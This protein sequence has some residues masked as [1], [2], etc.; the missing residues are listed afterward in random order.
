MA[1]SAKQLADAKARQAANYAKKNPA[2]VKAVAK[3]PVPAKYIPAKTTNT[4]AN[5]QV[6]IGNLFNNLRSVAPN[7]TL[8]QPST[9]SRLVAPSTVNQPATIAQSFD[10]TKTPTVSIKKNPSLDVSRP[11][12]KNPSFVKTITNSLSNIQKDIGYGVKNPKEV[13][14]QVPSAI[15]KVGNTVLD[16]TMRGISRIPAKA[17]SQ[18]TGQTLDPNRNTISKFVLGSDPVT[19]Y[20]EDMA[21]MQKWLQGKGLTKKQAIPAALVGS[22]GQIGLDYFGFGEGKVAEKAIVKATTEQAAKKALQKIGVESTPEMI[23][24]VI[25]IATPEEAKAF[26]SEAKNSSLYRAIAK[27]SSADFAKETLAGKIRPDI[28]DNVSTKLATTTDERMVKTIVD[29]AVEASKQ[30]PLTPAEI[31]S[32]GLYRMNKDKPI[33]QLEKEIAGSQATAKKHGL[34][35]DGVPEVNKYII[36]QKKAADPLLQGARKIN[37]SDDIVKALGQ[38]PYVSGIPPRWMYKENGVPKDVPFE[39]SK[40]LNKENFKFAP[41][42]RVAKTS[43]NLYHT[44]S[45]DNLES[46][47]KNGL[48]I[49]NKARFEG[50][51]SPNRLSFSAN[52]AGANYYGKQGDIMIRT[53]TSYKPTDLQHDLLAG[54]EGAYTT[55]KNIPP[56]ELEVKINGEWVSLDSINQSKGLPNH[57]LQEARR[58]KSA[59]ELNLFRDYEKSA[60]VEKGIDIT[61]KQFL[62]EKAKP[63]EILN[64]LSPESRKDVLSKVGRTTSITS[65]S[66]PIL[67]SSKNGYE[68]MD[69]GHA[70]AGKLKENKPIEYAKSQLTDIWKEAQGETPTSNPKVS[71]S[72]V[73]PKEKRPRIGNSEGSPSPKKRGFIET[74]T[75]SDQTSPALKSRLEQAPGYDPITNAET[76]A[77]AKNLVKT[78]P[79]AAEDFVM[80]AKVPSAGHTATGIELIKKLQSQGRYERAA[81]IA[82]SLAEKL[83]KAGQ[84]IQA[85]RL[86]ENLSPEGVLIRAQK[87]IKEA[88]AN[89]WRWQKD[90]VL[91]GATAK[92]LSELAKKMGEVGGELKTEFADE[93]GSILNNLKRVTIGKKIS[94]A[95]TIAQLLNP[96]TIITRNPLGNELFYRL[97]RVNKYL[98]TPIDWARSVLTGADRTVTFRSAK[99]GEFWKNFLSGAKAGWQGKELRVKTQFDLHGEVFKSKWNPLRYAE[100]ALGATL[101]GF[102]NAAFM[103]AKNET[104]GEMAYLKAYNE[105][106]RGGAVKEAAIKYAKQVDDNV[107]QIA[108]NYGKYVTFQDENILSKGFSAVKRGL[109]VGQDF[110]LGDLVLKY[111]KTPGAL[112]MRGIEYSPAGFLKSAYDIAMPILKG[113]PINSREVTLGLTRAIIGT[114]GLT[115]MGYY[116]A[117]KGIITGK[118]NKDKDV[119][120]FEKTTGTGQYKINLSAL[121]RFVMS[122]FDGSSTEKQDGDW[123]YSYDWA[124]PLAVAVSIGANINQE[125]GISGKGQAA[126]VAESIAGASSTIQEQPLVSGL[127]KMFGYGDIL[128]GLTET[129]KGLPSSFTP[130]LSNQFRQYIDNQQRSTYSPTF[131]GQAKNLVKNKIPGLEKY[132]PEKIDV[133][134]KKQEIYQDGGNNIFNV[135]FNPGFS[136]TL[137]ETPESKMVMDMFEKSGQTQQFPRVTPTKVKVNGEDMVLNE[138]QNRDMQKFVGEKTMQA[139]EQLLKDET[140]VK[141]SDTEKAKQMSNVMTDIGQLAKKEL[142]GDKSDSSPGSFEE[143]QNKL[144][145]KASYNK[146]QKLI[147]EGKLKEA[148]AIGKALTKDQV[149]AYNSV[150]SAEQT[151]RT[152]KLKDLLDSS[153]KEVLNY[154]RSLRPDQQAKIKEFLTRKG[155]EEWKQK[156]IEARD[157]NK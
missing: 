61:K 80:N 86:Y 28:L 105:G 116:L 4:S 1:R 71:G 138:T 56:S 69:G 11:A 129:A 149:K 120:A 13:L 122:G 46:I 58:Y 41:S 142:L 144:E 12:T 32:S 73:L 150:R 72:Q 152:N 110:G 90:I 7:N 66:T 155:N 143:I 26:I 52:E 128:G 111:P 36:D 89:K 62:I 153:P 68:V 27:S 91:D 94:T 148:N 60:F 19:P 51:S 137:K 112:L 74:I 125:K 109:N 88:N 42:S 99:Q 85:A 84:Q 133:T 147:D 93:I 123:L 29:N 106:L 100:K 35:P 2:P 145:A 17:I 134:G 118:S 77:D 135:F 5:N 47:A 146:I 45:A 95:Q 102:D 22:I 70:L 115:G 31:E 107:I 40:I 81:I 65:K 75:K 38:R 39:M 79:I 53:K 14:S 117:D 98:A 96:K 113:R 43:N 127:K 104:L 37:T 132:L 8:S 87:L 124:Q 6:D 57:L 130:T 121:K 103:R 141:S 78:N 76:L 59:E 157:A 136:T 20:T 25:K 23:S 48:T 54:G 44:T 10:K 55:G 114:T 24:R 139:F 49:G 140:F 50:V 131:T 33:P 82:E 101:K 154:V 67:I 126:T 108:E 18:L 92:K 97:E 9:L 30:A 16:Y 156:Y 21:N 3:A 83:T 119:N 15:A 34:I 63:S 151:K 64:L